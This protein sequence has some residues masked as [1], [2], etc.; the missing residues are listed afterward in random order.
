MKRVQ[1]CVVR[2][3]AISLALSGAGKLA[4]AQG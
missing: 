4:W 1:P 2:V 3:V